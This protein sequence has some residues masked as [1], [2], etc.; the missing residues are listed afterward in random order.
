MKDKTVLVYLP[1]KPEIAKANNLPVKLPVLVEDMKYI[2][3][4]DRID[5]DVIIRGLEAQN[6]IEQNDYYESYLLY[7][8]FEAF[9]RAL[10]SGNLEEAGQF[11]EKTA[12]VKKD[13]RYHFYLGLLL[14]EVMF[15]SIPPAATKLSCRRLSSR[16]RSR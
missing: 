8:Y 2:T 5:L 7:Y 15:K 3:D 9:K 16:S 14:R 12:R 10:N 6:R 4:R 13:Y 11:L 1:L